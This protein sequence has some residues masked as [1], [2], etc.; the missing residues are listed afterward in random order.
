MKITQ[1]YLTKETAL[2]VLANENVYL[3]RF[4]EQHGT[5]AKNRKVMPSHPYGISLKS[6]KTLS[7]KEIIEL[8][9]SGN[10]ALAEVVLEES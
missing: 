10:A 9:E 8:V 3:V 1:M 4:S 6:I 2:D 7:V 5:R